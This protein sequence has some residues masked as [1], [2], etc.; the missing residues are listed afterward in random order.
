MSGADESESLD[1]DSARRS[2]P[3]PLPTNRTRH[4][5]CDAQAVGGDNQAGDQEMSALAH[6]PRATLF[7]MIA[8]CA[9]AGPIAAA[10]LPL[11]MPS[12]HDE[13]GNGITTSLSL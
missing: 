11:Q 12:F 4:P 5:S 1:A 3:K 7:A 10:E 2:L 6:A 9:G 13:Q 8:S